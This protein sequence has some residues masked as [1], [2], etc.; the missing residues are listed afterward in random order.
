[1][2]T[3]PALSILDRSRTRSGQGDADALRATLAR[4]RR[5]EAAGVHGFWLAEHHAVPGV[6]GPAPTVLLAAVAAATTRLRVGT[7]GVMLPNHRPFVVA[8]Q[9]AVLAALHPGRLEIGVGR[10]L[11]F[12][13][14]VRRA[15]GAQTGEDAEERLVELLDWLHGR[16][17]V[18]LRPRV[19]APPVWLLATGAGLATAARLGLPVVVG[20]RLLRDVEPVRRYRDEHPGG[21]V[22]LLLDVVVADDEEAARRELLP[23]AVALA[24]VRSRGE[25][26]P[27]P[28]PQEAAAAVGSRGLT[29]RERAD[30]ERYLG[31][32]VAGTAPQVRRRLQELLERTGAE[33]LLVA[34]T[35]YDEDV[36]AA[37]D[38]RLAELVPELTTRLRTAG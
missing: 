4:A 20:G 7:A 14:P 31:E 3:A 32:A 23:Q 5:A 22:S 1:M 30:V 35:P 6:V 19:P 38:A 2:P 12:T 37:N 17:P 33:E 25:F 9:L 29:G 8:E 16:G 11:G 24:R 21:R 15:L 13:A 10:S 28:T 18:T 34:A 36:E 26:G 27:L